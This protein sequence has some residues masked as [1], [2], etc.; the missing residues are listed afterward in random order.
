MKIYMLIVIFILL[1]AFYIVSEKNLS[2]ASAQDR[3][4][5][6]K[7]YISW[8]GHLFEN[9][10]QISGYIIKLDWLPKQNSSSS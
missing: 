7:A 9:A 2:L 10:K 4:E 5:F 3:I 1:G 6:G 8:Y